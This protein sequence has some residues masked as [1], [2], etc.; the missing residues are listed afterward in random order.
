MN[1]GTPLK[2]STIFRTTIPMSAIERRYCLD[3]RNEVTIQT[4]PD[5]IWK[6]KKLNHETLEEQDD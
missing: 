5:I 1:L 2:R 4:T 3:D 6:I